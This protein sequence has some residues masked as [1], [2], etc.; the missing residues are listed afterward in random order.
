MKTA[1]LFSALG[2]LAMTAVLIYGFTIGNFSADGAKIL[3]NPWGIVSLVDL[4]VGFTLFSLWIAY[5][6]E[7]KLVAALWIIAMM[8]L[9][10]FAGSLY[11]LLHLVFSKGDMARFFMGKQ[12]REKG[13]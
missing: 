13:R 6:E 8:I 9:G 3:A 1:K 10:F 7:N 5:R 12:H 11:V 2:L 4:Y